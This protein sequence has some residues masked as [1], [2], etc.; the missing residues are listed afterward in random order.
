MNDPDYNDWLDLLRKKV[1]RHNLL[2]LQL[3]A[4]HEPAR[5]TLSSHGFSV[6]GLR[7]YL[8][9]VEEVVDRIVV[10]DGIEE[11]T[12]PAA[13]VSMG[14]LRERIFRGIDS[15][16]RYILLAR[17][18]RAAFP[19]VP[20]SSLLDDA[21]FARGPVYGM[22][23]TSEW[24]T[25]QYDGLSV[26]NV[27][28]DALGELGAEMCAALDRVIFDSML[29]GE[30]ALTAFGAREL[31]A[32]AG[33]GLISLQAAERKWNLPDGLH[34]LK[35]ALADVLAGEV[36]PQSQLGEVT[37]GLWELERMIRRSIRARAIAAWGKSWRTQCLQGDLSDRVLGRATTS[38]YQAANSVKLIRDPLEWLTLSELLDLKARPEIG[39]LGLETVLWRNF[40]DQVMPI[41]NRLAHMR[42]LYPG[43]AAN[44][45]K[46][47]RVLEVKLTPRS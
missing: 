40:A 10:V 9:M 2:F 26:A 19:A 39:N 25:C 16:G 41:R 5:R 17:A 27:L 35:D 38:T 43:D 21:T 30:S 45:V 23:D 47:L 24:P 37:C 32:L 31:E 28:R 42:N 29:F 34:P 1:G 18:P 4:A 8:A 11:L 44:V 12:R 36:K 13:D 7:E 15:G 22:D 3:G 33:A 46:W 6:I 20:G 14:A